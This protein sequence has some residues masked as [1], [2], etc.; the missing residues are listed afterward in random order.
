MLVSES[1][2]SGYG[3][4]ACRQASGSVSIATVIDYFWASVTGGRDRQHLLDGT[5]V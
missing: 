5:T 4:S 2:A 1:D 3:R